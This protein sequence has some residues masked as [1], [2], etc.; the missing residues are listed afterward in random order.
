[1][2]ISDKYKSRC[3]KVQLEGQ[4]VYLLPDKTAWIFKKTDIM[5]LNKNYIHISAADVSEH[6]AL[7]A[8]LQDQD[9]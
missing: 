4:L 8:K 2:L 9:Q 1:M 5:I 7:T 6:W 3:E